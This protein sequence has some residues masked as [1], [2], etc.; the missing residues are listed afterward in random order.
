MT[1][2]RPD[3][4]PNTQL[5]AARERMLS[6]TGSQRPMSR[7]ELA[8][9]INAYLWHKHRRRAALDGNYIGK[10]ERGDHRWPQEIYREAFRAVLQVAADAEIGFYIIRTPEPTGTEVE[11]P[12]A[13]TSSAVS[14][15]DAFET[16]AQLGENRRTLLRAIAGVAAASGLFGHRWESTR[17]VGLSDITRLNA[18]AGLYRSLDY[19][20]G[21]GMLLADVNKF[22]ESASAL[23]DL[24]YGDSVAPSLL[25]AVAAVRQLAGWTA[26]DAGRHSDAQRHLLSAERAAAAA[27]DVLLAARVRYCQARQFQHLRHHRDALD[28]VRLARQH[29]GGV[30]TPAIT[31]ML[32]GAEAASLAALGNGRDA[33]Q[34]LGQASDSFARV[35]ADREPEWMRFYDK[36]EVFAQYG[37]VYRDMARNDRS[38]GPAAVKWVNKAITSFGPQNVRSTVLNEVGL[39]SALFL[40]DEPEQALVVGRGVLTHAERLSSSR[41]IDRIVNL[42][43]D[44]TRHRTRR[45]VAAFERALTRIEAK[46]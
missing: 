11:P 24:S 3:L 19:E 37:R 36:G 9:T 44:L 35:D 7:Q 18:V 26:F 14:A 34:I 39:C 20:F 4:T 31:A 23:L 45:D 40:A 46:R 30:A 12:I 8:E 33:L 41:V 42:R 6:P 15:D 29:V 16:L 43:R 17:R 5:R 22:A 25:S 10:L 2:R 1:R 13:E 27:E 28:T 32:L 38:H 21:G